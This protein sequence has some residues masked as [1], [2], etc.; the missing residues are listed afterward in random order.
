MQWNDRPIRF[1]AGLHGNEKAPVRALESRGLRFVLGNPRAY[2][3]NVR[4]IERDL[5]ASFGV[6]DGS[7]EA[8]RAAEILRKIGE[9]EVVVDFHTTSASS[10]PFA[11]LTDKKMLPLAERIGVAYAVLMTHNIKKGHALINFRDGISVEMHGYDTEESFQAT[12]HV[13]RALS[14]ER[15]VPVRVYEVYGVIKELGD[16]ENFTE[17][18]DGFTPVLVGEQSYDFIGLKARRLG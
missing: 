5:N 9:K 1:V 15:S 18:P 6:E 2:E 14:E 7:Y 4:F 3:R 11:I 13:L 17:H 12:L 16:Y 10:V 8:L